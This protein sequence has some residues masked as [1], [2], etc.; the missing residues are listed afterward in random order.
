MM[1]DEP[2][3]KSDGPDEEGLWFCRGAE[4]SQP[5]FLIWFLPGNPCTIS[6]YEPFLSRL[7]ELLNSDDWHE[8]G[9]HN[10]VGG[11]TLPGFRSSEPAMGQGSLPAGL[12]DQIQNAEE[13]IARAVARSTPI[14]EAGPKVILIAHSVGAYMTLEILRRRAQ[15]LNQLAS[16]DVIGAVLLFPT[17]TEIAQSMH[18]RILSV[19]MRLHQSRHG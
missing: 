11:C 5:N 10:I 3:L 7:S 1:E 14:R 6:Y 12:E 15:Y 18:G 13:S 17:V 16:L 2:F 19:G 8:N 4:P 9:Q